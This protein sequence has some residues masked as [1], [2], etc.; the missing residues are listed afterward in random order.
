M[1]SCIIRHMKLLTRLLVLSLLLPGCGREPSGLESGTTRGWTT[2]GK[3]YFQIP[4]DPRTYTLETA[5]C[6]YQSRVPDGVQ[7]ARSDSSFTLTLTVTLSPEQ[8]R[9]LNR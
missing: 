4:G 8:L 6:G 3:S 5:V 9:R 2:A 7:I 1:Q